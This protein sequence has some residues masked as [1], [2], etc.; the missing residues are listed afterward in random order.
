[1]RNQ[2]LSYRSGNPVL[3]SKAFSIK[4]DFA[5]KMTIEGTV[6]KTFML[7][8][9]VMGSGYFAWNYLYASLYLAVPAAILAVIFM[10]LIL[11]N[12]KL[13]VYLAPLYAICQGIS[14]G[15]FSYYFNSLY[16]GIAITAISYTFCILFGLLSIYRLGL[17]KPSE[18]FKL[19]VGAATFGIMLIYIVDIIM[20]Y[21]GTGIPMNDINNSS[22]T[23]IGF[24]VFVIIIA[25]MNLVVDFDFI[26]EGAEKGAPKYMEWY[27][28][29]GLMVTLIWLYFEI[30]K[31]LAKM[32]SRK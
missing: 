5:D 12:K 25:S 4:D 26:E 22:M 13:I 19:G 17:I 11:F 7:L 24:S 18:N 29:F 32:N 20:G 23:S 8:T 31:L 27:G 30:L 9:L 10:F 2:H 1:M 14:M 3:T 6:N 16:E 21:F 15:M 28:A